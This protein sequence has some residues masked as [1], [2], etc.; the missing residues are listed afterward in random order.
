VRIEIADPPV[1]L[2]GN[3]A[4]AEREFRTRRDVGAARKPRSCRAW[5]AVADATTS[6]SI[7]SAPCR[8]AST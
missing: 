7:A 2:S 6:G 5:Y 8:T 1:A 4:R 3:L